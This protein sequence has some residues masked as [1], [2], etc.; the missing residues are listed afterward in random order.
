[1]DISPLFTASVPVFLQYLASLRRIV[2]A[3]EA[4]PLEQSR[5]VLRARLAPDMHPFYS[6]AEMAIQFAR[7]AAFPLAGRHVPVSVHDET[8]F[9]T[10]YLKIEQVSGELRSLQPSEFAGAQARLIAE[11]AGQAE[12]RLPAEQFLHNYALPNFFFHLN[13]AYAIARAN[14][15]ALGKATYDGIHIYPSGA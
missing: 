14:G 12:V 2:G 3:V 9:E 8:S 4:L 13:M 11:Q 1:M 6:Q 15:A 5:L 10:L 7:R